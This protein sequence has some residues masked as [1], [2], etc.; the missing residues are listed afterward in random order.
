MP[1]R[2]IK[3]EREESKDPLAEDLKPAFSND[4]N[5]KEVPLLQLGE[6]QQEELVKIILEDYENATNARKQT[7]WGT[8]KNG[9][10]VDFDSKYANLVNLYEGEDDIRPESWMCG[11]SL[12]VAQA[13]VEMLVARLFPAVWNEE[14]IR[15]RPVEPTDKKTVERINKIMHW[16]AVVWMKMGKDVREYVRS[17]I[18]FGTAYVETY[19]QVKKKDLDQ[20]EQ[21][22]VMGP[23]GQPMLD[24]MTG[25]P[26]T[27]ETKVL[28]AEERP[29]IRVIPVTKILTQPGQ[30]D[31]QKEPI[32]KLEDFYFHELLNM[33]KSGLMQNVD[34]KL[35]GAIEKTIVDK[36]GQELEKAERISDMNAKRRAHLVETII[37]YGNYDADGDGF[38]EDI[39][40]MVSIKEE[41]FLRAFK[42]VKISR[43]AKRPINQIDFVKRVHKLLGIG[44]LEQIKPLAEE[45]DACFR[46]LQDANTLSI[47]KWGFYDPNSDY[48]P[49]E[50]VAKPRAMYPVT[51]PQQNVYF[52]DMNI[53][54]E[55]LLNAIRLVLEF[56]ERLTAASSYM[57]GKES[58]VVGGSGTATRTNAITSAAEVRFNLPANNMREGLAEIMTDLFDLCHLNMPDGLETRILG[59]SGE[60]IFNTSEEIQD[61]FSQTVDAYLLPDVAFGDVNTRREL[62]IMLYDKFV[63]GG[64]PLVTGDVNRIWHASAG[65]LKS[66]GEEPVEWLGPPQSSKETNDPM[67]E[68]TIIREGRVIHAE[69]QE[70]HLEHILAHEQFLQELGGSLEVVT[71]PKTAIDALRM[72]IEEHKQL[73]QQIMQ[74]QAGQK[75]GGA[76]GEQGGNNPEAG[77]GANAAPGELGVQSDANPAKSTADS[78]TAGTTLGTPQVQ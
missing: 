56:I 35:Q 38:D 28:H 31:L 1:G 67:V 42:L 9:K 41:I 53:P 21:T 5:L 47:M 48:D 8:D 16:V 18:M 27:V 15:W 63:L 66:F 69:P 24:E 14:S 2:E 43:K 62:S 36:F 55:R 29:A 3:D 13:V 4:E 10:A 78:Q 77:G 12:K 6:E 54:I 70:N 11:R 58:E 71:W 72:H 57:L 65:I 19:W 44:V 7:S 40:A 39:C 73:M 45:I 32:I 25:Q 46:Q 17:S 37:W 20:T 34:D 30:T 74:F 52:P 61:A 23:D 59:E 22:P 68:H 26:M 64:N 49:A 75:K 50:H 60:Q 33:Q 76:L 51:N